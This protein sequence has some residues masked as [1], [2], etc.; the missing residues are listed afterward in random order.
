M[1]AER[2]RSADSVAARMRGLL[3]RRRIQMGE[4]L[5]LDPCRQVHTFGMRYPIDVVFCGR[6]GLVTHIVRGMRPRRVSAFRWRA[7][8]AIE[9][10]AGAA[11]G[12]S[13]GDVLRVEEL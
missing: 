1:V 4:G 2:L 12:V 11:A 8:Y 5:L 7:R 3:G 9:L 6:D 13:V 10:A